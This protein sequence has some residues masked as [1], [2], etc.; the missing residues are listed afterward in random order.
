MA[1]MHLN[2]RLTEAATARIDP[3]DRGFL[4]ADGLFETLRAYAGR[5]F[6]LDA[7]LAR[8]SDGAAALD[9][10]MPPTA[11]L[12]AAV[13]ETLQ[14]NGH[15]EASIRITLTRGAGP[16]GLLP[17]K[18]PNPTWMVTTS[19]FADSGPAAWKAKLVTIRRNEHSPLARL[20]S[21]AYLDNVLA[22]KE[23][24]APD[25]D[26]ALMLNTAGRLACGSRSNLF[27]VL[28][29]VLVTPPPSEGALPG[30]ARRQ[31]LDLAAMAGIEARE[32][33]LSIEDLKLASE[34]FV[35]NSLIEVKP[36]AGVNDSAF[37]PGPI[38]PKL[39]QLYTDLVRDR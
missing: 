24:A 16:R 30:I 21:L 34:V 12:A 38:V 17:P 18:E 37:A 15:R 14:A 36:L 20:K 5:P 13:A 32:T 26:E 10:P 35:S 23:A 29:G 27:L 3:A 9:L 25:A 6:A 31:L 19:P 2:G 11:E 8:L 28:S 33:P 1:M 4:L 7:H 22:L 39:R